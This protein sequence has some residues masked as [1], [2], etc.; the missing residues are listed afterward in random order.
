MGSMTVTR[1]YTDLLGPDDTFAVT[2]EPDAEEPDK[3]F[4]R[5]T[6]TEPE[7]PKPRMRLGI[8]CLPAEWSGQLAYFGKEKVQVSRSFGKD[9][10]YAVGGAY[11]ADSATEWTKWG[12]EKWAGADPRTLMVL[13][14]KD[15]ADEFL[16]AWAATFPAADELAALGF[17]G[18]VASPWHEPEDDVRKGAITW[19]WL[20]AQGESIAAW[21]DR[22]P[23]GHELIKRVG[24]I[25][26]RYDL[27]D[28]GNDPRN[29]GFPGMD[30]FMFDTYQSSPSV[31]RYW[32]PAEMVDAVADRIHAAYPGIP[33][34]IPEYGYAKQA[35]DSTGSGWASAHRSLVQHMRNRGD[36]EFAVAFNSAGSMPEVP[37]YTSGPVAELYRDELLEPF[38]A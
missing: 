10:L 22:H 32:T 35:Y 7:P 19:A 29:A 18:V 28:L 27:V 3:R 24:P 30:I 13:S 17:P 36:V 37:F 20:R 33:L 15:D 23:R 4:L 31:G 8:T 9:N 38:P 26:T 1:T 34:G 12:T 11:D 25:L 5:L 2:V 14:V 16:D 21:R 6:I